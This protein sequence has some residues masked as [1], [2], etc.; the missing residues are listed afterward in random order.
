MA[1]VER[2]VLDAIIRCEAHHVNFLDTALLQVVSES[3]VTTMGVIEERAV[4]VDVSLGPFVKNVSDA[5]RVESRGELSTVRVLNAMHRPEDLFDPIE[6]DAI[7]RLF[8]RMVCSEAAVIGWMP[9]FGCDDEV[10]VS[11]Q[12]IRERDDLI[13][14]RYR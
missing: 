5:T 12:F 3:G 13:T 9:I 8:A 14:M 2:A 1:R 11:L 7:P 10:E 6:N 4:A